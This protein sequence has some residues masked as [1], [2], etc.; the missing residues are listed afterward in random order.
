MSSGRPAPF[1]DYAYAALGVPRNP[2]IPA[3]RDPHYF[4]MGLCG[5]YRHDLRKQTQYC[6]MFKTPT[7]RNVA[8]RKV[9]FHNGVFHSLTDVMRFY[10]ERDTDPR[11]WYPV[12][13]GKVDVYDDLPPRYRGNV[14]NYDAPMNRVAGQQPALDARE[15]A[16]IIAF[17]KTLDDGYSATAGGPPIRRHGKH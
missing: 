11:K 5:P 12:V 1:T 2:A 13:H 10:V 15:I 4:D 16:D 7:L 14:D 8:T 9:F 3:N 6:G 17:L